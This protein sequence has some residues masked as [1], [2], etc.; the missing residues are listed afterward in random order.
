M[1]KPRKCSE[2]LAGECFIKIEVYVPIRCNIY[3][4]IFYILTEKWKEE[5]W[6]LIYELVNVVKKNKVIQSDFV[7]VKL[8]ANVD[9]VFT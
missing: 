5:I 7:S 1:F 9:T 3:T 8:K 4:Y 2:R 6:T